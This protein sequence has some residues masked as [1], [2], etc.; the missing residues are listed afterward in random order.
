[1]IPDI[2]YQLGFRGDTQLSRSL[3]KE[4]RQTHLRMNR[5]PTVIDMPTFS[6]PTAILRCKAFGNA[7]A[8]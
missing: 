3:G 6:Q 7:A 1:M 2:V 8:P 4:E 5:R